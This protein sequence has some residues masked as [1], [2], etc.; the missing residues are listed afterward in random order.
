MDELRNRDRLDVFQIALRSR[1]D[2]VTV[3]RELEHGL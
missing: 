3:R 2:K 1:C